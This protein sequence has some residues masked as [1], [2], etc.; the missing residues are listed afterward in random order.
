MPRITFGTYENRL[1]VF[2]VPES[3]VPVVG[4]HL[5]LGGVDYLVEARLWDYAIWPH[6]YIRLIEEENAEI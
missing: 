4:D 3:E 2:N 1:A 5:K 6:L